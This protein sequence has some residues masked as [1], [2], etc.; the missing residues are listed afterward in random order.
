MQTANHVSAVVRLPRELLEEVFRLTL[1]SKEHH[2]HLKYLPPSTDAFVTNGSPWTLTYVCSRWRDIAM[3]TAALWATLDIDLKMVEASS[4][5]QW[6]HLL[7]TCLYRSREHPLSINISW[8]DPERLHVYTWNDT[9]D[10]VLSVLMSTTHRWVSLYASLPRKCFLRMNATHHQFPVLQRA[11]IGES[12]YD[13]DL[14]TAGK[15]A[16]LSRAPRL[17][18]LAFGYN[19]E[20]SSTELLTSKAPFCAWIQYLTIYNQDPLG[21]AQ[22]ALQSCPNLCN[23]YVSVEGPMGP[24]EDDPVVQH[25]QLESITMDLRPYVL[26]WSSNPFAYF[27]QL[28]TPSLHTL[29]LRADAISVQVDYKLESAPEYITRFIERSQ[30]TITRL[31]LDYMPVYEDGF[32]DLLAVIPSIETLE[33]MPLDDLYMTNDY[34]LYLSS[35]FLECLTLSSEATS[36]ADNPLLPSLQTLTLMDR[37]DFNSGMTAAKMAESRWH[38]EAS[39][40][41]AGNPQSVARL[42]AI[43]LVLEEELD[44]EA[45]EKFGWMM[46]EGLEVRVWIRQWVDKGSEEGLL[47]PILELILS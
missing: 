26:D 3:T 8:A 35:T 32:M 13:E 41:D 20:L 29:I 4:N 23:I 5:V 11:D 38:S 7:E 42:K 44:E 6:S 10:H 22:I 17:R 2:W 45:A 34:P 39:F 21:T 15:Y 47:S 19:T 40:N 24:I 18:F 12:H 28:V 25:R 14:D 16:F 33:L 9:I 37:H 43:H 46:E 36:T 1:S 31:R 30:C 27:K